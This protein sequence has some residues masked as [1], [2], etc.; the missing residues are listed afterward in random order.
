MALDVPAAQLIVTVTL[1]LALAIGV[2]AGLSTLWLAARDSDWAAD[3]RGQLSVAGAAAAAV[4]LLASGA[5]LWL[6]AASMAEVP[7]TAAGAASLSILTATHFGY[8]WT[9]G[10]SALV[11]GA[12]AVALRPP[13]KGRRRW[14]FLNLFALAAFLYTRSV[15]SHAAADGDFGIRILADWVHLMLISV[16]AGEV[17]VAG[18]LTL[19]APLN[20]EADDHIECKRY[21]E[22]LSASAT[23]A[24]G[25]IVVTGAVNAWYNVGSP[26][27]LA[28]NPYGV[29]LLLKLALVA[30]AV[31][32]GGFN[33][34]F[35]MPSLTAAGMVPATALR[36]FTLI[37]RLESA[38]LL[39]VLIVA[40]ILSS[41]SPPT[42]G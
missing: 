4:A 34:V 2:G 21:I 40:A 32:L 13:G 14:I 6:K 37:L 3:R 33:R 39:G 9:G 11:L 5:L 15:V 28:G 10:A 30:V 24:L 42:A 17:F 41:T 1:N 19:A 27:T 18:L 26:Y 35:V 25:G 12:L 7:V 38:V 22:A 8:S 23:Y 20:A 29:A 16:W 36:H 31:L